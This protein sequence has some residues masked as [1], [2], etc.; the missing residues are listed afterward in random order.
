M[1]KIHYTD[2]RDILM[3]ISFL[4][5][6]NIHKVITSPGTTNHTLVKSMQNDP[7]FEM[8]SSVDERSAAY[9]A[10]GLCSESG[11]PVV[12]T[13]TEA[14]ASRNYMPGLTEAFYRKLPILALTT[15]HGRNNVGNLVAQ[16]LDHS[17]IPNDIAVYHNYIPAINSE[18]DYK[19]AE[20]IM[21]EA[22][23]AL[24][25]RGGGPVYLTLESGS[26]RDY[27]VTDLPKVRVIT[28]CSGYGDWPSLPHGK[29]GIFIG[30]HNE[31]SYEAT[32]CVDDFCEKT[33]AV[34]FCDHTSGYYGKF[35]VNYALVGGQ[36]MY[37]S[38]L[39]KLRLL[40]RVG[41][42][43]GD[44][45]SGLIEGQATEVW[46]VNEDGR[47]ADKMGKL[48]KVFEMPEEQFFS[49]YASIADNIVQVG[50][51][52]IELYREEK[53]YI[54]SNIP[55]LPFSKVW[56]AQ[57]LIHRL[58][59]ESYIHFSILGSLR[60]GNFFDLPEGVRG[61][62]NVGGFGIDGATSTLIGASLANKD[63]IHFLMTGDLAF[64]YDLN[65]IGNRHIGSNVRILLINNGDGTEF[66]QYWHPISAFSKEE[67]DLYMA[68][69]GHFGN[70]SRSLVR[71]IAKDLGFNYVTADTKDEFRLHIDKFVQP[72]MTDKPIIFETFTDS[73]VDSQAVRTMRHLVKDSG[74]LKRL[75]K[76]K[77]TDAV[78]NML[79]DGAI[80][81]A[82]QV[83]RKK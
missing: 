16:V 3:V 20:H 34:V 4:K 48:T 31:W 46:R 23:L 54:E 35:K 18:K 37:R 14:T 21:N 77:M 59:A 65:A 76:E 49:Y 38:E 66:R 83:L 1:E 62:C 57:Q 12:I 32:R 52:P 68:A 58:P 43:S 73:E 61:G 75:A 25:H 9:M 15:S 26:S 55:E 74:Y 28:R 70:Q 30:S 33:G 27:S 82:K 13:C 81:V 29:I 17:A 44:Y 67:A 47:L 10:C 79:G 19:L 7:F 24:F 78:K 11:E 56:I 53:K 60:A 50:S 8:Y 80:D 71:D 39:S 22:F 5:K 2:E 36:D 41:E 63:R 42:I 51:H 72:E 45:F 40:I 64:F 69:G 6:Y